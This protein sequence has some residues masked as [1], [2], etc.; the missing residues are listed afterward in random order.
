MDREMAGAPSSLK[1]NEKEKRT[2]Q[3]DGGNKAE[4]AR[5]RTVTPD[6]S[7]ES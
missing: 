7:I 3:T 5:K 2:L 6:G 1:E 4:E